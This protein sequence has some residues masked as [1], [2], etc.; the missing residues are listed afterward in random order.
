MVKLTNVLVLASGLCATAFSLE[1]ARIN[2]NAK[3][4]T[5][6]R[7]TASAPIVHS[8]STFLKAAE[9]SAEI[10]A[11]AKS[12]TVVESKKSFVDMIWNENTKLTIYLAV[13]YLGNIYYN[14]YNKRACIA[15]GKNAHGN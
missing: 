11:K 4:T 14:I 13:W 7:Q 8:S 9:E 3:I 2:N 6:I 10:V 5:S 12:T 1:R 15:L